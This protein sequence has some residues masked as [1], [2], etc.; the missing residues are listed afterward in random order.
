MFYILLLL[1]ILSL[2]VD[3]I[4]KKYYILLL[5]VSVLVM[6]I[7]NLYENSKEVFLVIGIIGFLSKKYFVKILKVKDKLTEASKKNSYQIWGYT[8][9]MSMES[10]G[11]Y[12][13][14]GY[15][16]FLYNES[17]IG[18]LKVLFLGVLYNYSQSDFVIKDN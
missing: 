8:I 10:I 9:V 15:N 5:G 14:L 3:R 17:A 11:I 4:S 18:L 6:Q 16:Y 1:L 7:F 12:G 13:F 2:T